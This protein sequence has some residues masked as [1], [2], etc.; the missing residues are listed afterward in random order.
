M[1]TVAVV[2]AGAAGLA[3]AHAAAQAG[4]RVTVYER[5]DRV[6]GTT[7]LSGGVAWLPAND[8]AD[9]TVEDALAYMRSLALGDVEPEHV[10]TFVPMSRADR[11][12]ARARRR[13][14]AGRCCRIPTTTRERPGGRAD[15]GRSLEPVAC[16]APASV[17]RSCA[18]PRTAGGR[19]PTPSCGRATR[20]PRS[21]RAAR[22]RGTFTAG[23]ALI[24]AC[25]RPASRPG[26]RCARA[27]ASPRSRRPT[28]SSSRAA[29]SSAT[30]RSCARSCA[31][32]WS[33]PTGV[34]T[35]EGD[36]LRIGD[37]R[38]GG[39]RDDER[40]WWAPAVRLPGDTIDGRPMYRLMLGERARSRLPRSSTVR[41]RRFLDES[42]NYNDVGRTL[43]DFDAA[44]FSYGHV[45]GLARLRRRLPRPPTGSS[46]SPPDDP[47]PA[48][49]ERADT[50]GGL[51]E[52]MEIPAPALAA[53]VAA[54]RRAAGPGGDPSSAAGSTRTTAF[55]VRSGRSGR[56]RTSR[57]R[58]C[59]GCLGTKGGPRT[60]PARPRPRGRRRG[61]D[62]GPLRR[63]A[64]PRR[65]RS[66]SPIPAP[67]AR[68]ARRS[69]SASAR[70][71]RRRR[72]P[73]PREAAAGSDRG[74]PSRRRDRRAARSPR[75]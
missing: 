64:T 26:W 53:T 8:H 10:E 46:P 36:G 62:P 75:L 59:P 48:W 61:R 45:P 31:G 33:P 22:R 4:A 23:Q 39:A 65:A 49:L 74:P 54:F 17:R 29:A 40:G 73:R 51:A 16:D 21:S 68:S 32:R 50:P 57:S 27:S 2:G 44:A 7:A 1:K 60:D 30:S 56:A 47:D 34:P 38:R 35:N 14:C 63:R 37:G 52:R 3:A 15:G 66:G 71:R 24:A 55:S 72:R 12:A 70:A 13:R 9:D 5:H 18:T 58:C 11:G 28:P 20:R 41:G 6:G 42:Q 19:S 67:A 69:S 43:Q 25:S